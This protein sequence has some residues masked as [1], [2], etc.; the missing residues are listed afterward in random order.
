MK[1]IRW[2]YTTDTVVVCENNIN[3][4]MMRDWSIVPRTVSISLEIINAQNS[5]FTSNS[6]IS[7]EGFS[8]KI[9]CSTDT[10]V[11]NII[12]VEYCIFIHSTC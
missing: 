4:I 5:I 2:P 12:A 7:E 10:I 8:R 9:K 11:I 1:S 6:E 3:N